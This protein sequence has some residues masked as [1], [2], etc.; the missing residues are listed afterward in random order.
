M[1]CTPHCW[2]DVHFFYNSIIFSSSSVLFC[3]FSPIL[4]DV[5]CSFSFDKYW[6]II[7]E[8]FFLCPSSIRIPTLCWSLSYHKFAGG[9]WSRRNVTQHSTVRQDLINTTF[10][11]KFR[12]VWE[13]CKAECAAQHLA[14]E[15]DILSVNRN[16]CLHLL[17]YINS[18]SSL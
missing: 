4:L 11:K 2:S 1:N 18:T 3:A 9:E 6:I 15:V 5:S 10:R 8:G 7:L 14:K 13:I 17:Y 12:A 16:W